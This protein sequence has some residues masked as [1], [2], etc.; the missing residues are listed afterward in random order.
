[1]PASF[2]ASHQRQSIAISVPVACAS[3]QRRMIGPVPVDENQLSRLLGN[4]LPQ[5]R[6]DRSLSGA[7]FHPLHGCG[8]TPGPYQVTAY[9]WGRYLV[10]DNYDAR[11]ACLLCAQDCPEQNGKR[12]NSGRWRTESA[13]A[14]RIVGEDNDH[15]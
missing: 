13:V 1:M 2:I 10:D 4:E 12:A 11:S 5:E 3:M 8:E 6:R 15:I 9:P 7:E 14:E